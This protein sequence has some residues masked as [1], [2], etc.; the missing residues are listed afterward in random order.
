MLAEQRLDHFM[1]EVLLP[2]AAQTRAVV[3]CSATPDQCALSAS[4]T[5]MYVA[6]RRRWGAKPPFTVISLSSATWDLYRTLAPVFAAPSVRRASLSGHTTLAYHTWQGA[7]A[8]RRT[9]G[10]GRR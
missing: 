10:C 1:S 6:Q 8:G 2:L 9:N 5:R 4:F 3:L 7:R